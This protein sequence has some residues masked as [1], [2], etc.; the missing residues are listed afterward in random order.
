MDTFDSQPQ[1]ASHSSSTNDYDS[2]KDYDCNVIS[3][4]VQSHLKKVFI[5]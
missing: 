3:P 5:S 2:A 4:A 1:L